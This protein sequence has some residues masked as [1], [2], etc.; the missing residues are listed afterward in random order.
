MAEL[1]KDNF[2]ECFTQ[3]GEYLWPSD[4]DNRRTLAPAAGQVV[5]VEQGAQGGV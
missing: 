1:G 3:A 2:D 5:D 4:K